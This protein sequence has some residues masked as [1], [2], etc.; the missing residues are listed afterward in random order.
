[1]RPFAD[2][3]WF[4]IHISLQLSGYLLGVAG[5]GIGLKLWQVAPPGTD[6]TVHGNL[7]CAVFSVATAQVNFLPV[8][9]CQG[10][11]GVRWIYRLKSLEPKAPAPGTHTCQVSG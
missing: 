4:Y 7:G 2:P 3:L 10:C 8:R 5:F 6:Y 9:C 11:G 1:M